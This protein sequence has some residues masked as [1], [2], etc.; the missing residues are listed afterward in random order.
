MKRIKALSLFAAVWGFASAR[1]F[2]AGAT[3]LDGVSNEFRDVYKRVA[4]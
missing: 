4:R 1:A 3:I 2:V